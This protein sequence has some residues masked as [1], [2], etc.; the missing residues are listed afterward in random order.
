MH[1]N[2]E[3]DLMIS[4]L[5]DEAREYIEADRA[6]EALKII[7]ETVNAHPEIVDERFRA[8]LA[9]IE[10]LISGRKI[11]KNDEQ[12]RA[13]ELLN[14]YCSQVYG[15]IE[16]LDYGE[17]PRNDLS[18]K[19][20]IWWCWLQG[21][22]KAPELVKA[23]RRSLDKLGRDIVQ[24]D[25]AN[26]AEYA[27]LPD[28]LIDCYRSGRMSAAHF[29]D[30][31][32]L[33]LLTERGG[34]WI[35]ATAFVSD[36]NLMDEV[37]LKSNLFAFRAIRADY[38]SR[39]ATYDN[40]LIHASKPSYI[41]EDI[42]RMLYAYWSREEG[43]KHYFLFH[44]LMNLACE[45][46]RDEEAGIPIWSTEPCHILQLEMLKPYNRS[47]YEQILRMSDVHKLTYKYDKDIDISGSFLEKILNEHMQ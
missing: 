12:Y 35:D 5:L 41:L 9:L 16:E 27:D 29:T 25:E 2:S 44:I 17:L 36:A 6:D 47:R 30:L 45:R 28:H 40:W 31:I 3:S 13:Y 7:G 18:D 8:E 1:M 10:K 32:R 14:R 39:Y 20:K 46:H 23:C 34:T 43:L 24:I 4:G 19:D 15:N 38:I 21:A 37:I 42:K 11:I 33:E 26:F 22:D